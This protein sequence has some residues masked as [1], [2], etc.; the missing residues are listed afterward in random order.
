MVWTAVPQGAR[1][2]SLTS[3]LGTI[4]HLARRR[5]VAVQVGPMAYLP[6]SF[7]CPE[8]TDAG[9]CG[10]HADK[11]IRC[12]TMPFYPYREEDDQD[13]F[14]VPRA[15]WACDVSKDAPAVYRDKR[16]VVREDFDEER[17]QLLAQAPVLKAYADRVVAAAPNLVRELEMLSQRPMG[18]RLAL[19]FTGIL[20]RLPEVDV[21]EFV[22]VQLPVLRKYAELTAAD[23]TMGDFHQ[24]YRNA[25][26]ALEAA[27]VSSRSA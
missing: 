9:L 1:S 4:V 14:L 20:P 19:S 6:P 8:L 10:I 3:R 27:A 25:I 2:F 23:T 13:E 21:P 18:G 24:H 12:R 11:P 17:R 5:Q 15:G 16:I 22:R 7:P 26:R